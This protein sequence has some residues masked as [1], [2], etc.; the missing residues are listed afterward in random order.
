VIQTLSEDNGS[1]ESKDIGSYLLLA[2]SANGYTVRIEMS[3]IRDIGGEN[4]EH[5]QPG[6]YSTFVYKGNQDSPDP[7]EPGSEYVVTLYVYGRED[8]RM[9]IKVNKWEEGGYIIPDTEDIPD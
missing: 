2:P 4:E 1:K 7:F 3:E 6:Y 9:S 5:R 8:V